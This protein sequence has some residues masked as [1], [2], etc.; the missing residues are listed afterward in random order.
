MNIRLLAFLILLTVFRL[1]CIGQFELMPDEAQYY[2]WS[3]RLDWCYFSKGPG[4]ALAIRGSTDLFGPTEFGVR[5]FSPLLALGTS[6]ILYVL[7]RRIYDARVATWAV[8]LANVTPI[9]NVGGL[10]MTIDPLSIFFWTAALYTL[11]R[12]LEHGSAGEAR[13]DDRAA[14]PPRLR[15]GLHWW[16]LSG[17]LIGA[18]FL[19][20]WTNIVE[21]LSVVLLVL[22]TPRFFR[23]HWAGLV[24]MLLTFIPFLIPPAI[25][26][27]RLDWP[28]IDHLLARGGLDGENQG[29]DF[30]SFFAFVGGHVV[31]SPLILAGMF[32]VLWRGTKD[33]GA[34]WGRALLTCGPKIHGG[35]KRHPFALTICLLLALT[36]Y[37][38]GNYRE[39][40]YW[41]KAAWLVLVVGAV[42]ALYRAKEAANIY[43]RSRFLV[44]FALPLILLYAVISLRH[45]IE[46]NWTAPAM[47]GVI[48]LVARLTDQLWN[49]D[50]HKLV[51]TGLGLGVA[52]TL[53]L[54]LSDQVRSLGVPWP[55]KRDPST[56]LRGW[57]KGAEA[58]DEFRK[59]YE[60]ETGKPVFLIAG[61]YGVASELCFYL[62]EK[63]IESPGHP[64][65][66]VVESPVPENQFYYWG[67]Y[68]EYEARTTPVRDDQAESAE[69]GI[70][71]FAGRTALYIT[72]RDEGRPPSIFKKTFTTSKIVRNIEL[73]V[74]GETYRTLR[75]F[76]CVRYKPGQVLD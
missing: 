1:V 42:A 66:Y 15:R 32:W 4:V 74:E 5:F 24:V 56:R 62:P 26:N 75:I 13:E 76:E 50:R 47:V 73:K 14:P 30:K 28:T 69:D 36:L 21:L 34:R 41:H 64:A 49:A 43:W 6:L 23:Q 16:A 67:R 38:T 31:Y 57:R 3:Q 37:F 2:Q 55:M 11:W 46:L 29:L 19:C 45:D 8:V 48:I 39:E 60:K 53:I 68:D 17:A 61:H 65:V 12:A 33:S 63:R 25:W 40:T 22:L 18:G 51:Y 71:R 72:D 44:A 35:V 54:M 9:F 58:V 7:A 10:L 59:A 52:M 20:K 27:A 70:S